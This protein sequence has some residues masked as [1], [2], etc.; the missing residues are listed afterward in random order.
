MPGR[1]RLVAI[2]KKDLEMLTR[3]VIKSTKDSN[4]ALII[5]VINSIA[6]FSLIM[7]HLVK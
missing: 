5:S 2:S 4:L 6:I 7:M 3:N 1:N